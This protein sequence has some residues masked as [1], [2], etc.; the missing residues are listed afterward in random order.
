VPLIDGGTVRLPRLIG[1]SRAL[2]LV[3]TG[4]PVDAREA[5]AIGLANRLVPAGEALGAAQALA[6]E[7]AALPQECLRGDRASL[8]GQ[9]GMTE[10]E[11]MGREFGIGLASLRA[12]GVAGAARF[13]GGEGRH[14]A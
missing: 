14:G 6:R 8:V 9:W 3:L 1:E 4:R 12:D 10:P 13:A 7:L 5:Y 11:A 2:D